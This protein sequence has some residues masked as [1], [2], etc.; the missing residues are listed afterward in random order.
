MKFRIFE[1]M[2][3]ISLVGNVNAGMNSPLLIHTFPSATGNDAVRLGP[4]LTLIILF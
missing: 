1:I 3:I 2:A 4:N